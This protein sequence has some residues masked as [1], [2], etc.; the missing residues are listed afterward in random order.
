MEGVVEADHV[1]PAPVVARDLDGV[2]YGLGA[3]VDEPITWIPV[4]ALFDD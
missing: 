1:P 4:I 2:L 3:G